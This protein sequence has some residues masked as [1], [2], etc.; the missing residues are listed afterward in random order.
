MTAAAKGIKAVEALSFRGNGVGGPPR[1]K[2]RWTRSPAATAAEKLRAQRIDARRAPEHL[3]CSREPN[4]LFHPGGRRLLDQDLALELKE[5]FIRFDH[6]K[7]DDVLLDF[8]R[9][10]GRPIIVAGFP[11]PAARQKAGPR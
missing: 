7:G 2:T 11:G 1:R 8:Q 10:Q 5:A 6:A 4:E 3:F 9:P